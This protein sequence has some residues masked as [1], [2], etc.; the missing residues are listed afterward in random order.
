M[1]SKGFVSSDTWNKLG[2]AL[3]SMSIIDPAH[4]VA[5]SAALNWYKAVTPLVPTCQVDVSDMIYT[6]PGNT[7][8]WLK[9]QFIHGMSLIGD[10][11]LD[12]ML[13]GGPCNQHEHSQTQL[14]EYV[15][16]DSETQ[17]ILDCMIFMRYKYMREQLYTNIR[18]ETISITIQQLIHISNTCPNSTPNNTPP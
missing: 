13:V 1:V 8:S 10:A 4:S 2:Q 15:L 12:K 3:Q 9:K 14:C 11:T 5:R 6:I 18:I 16:C 17:T 7:L